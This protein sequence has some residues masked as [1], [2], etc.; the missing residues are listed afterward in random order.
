[1]I[2]KIGT[3]VGNETKKE[4]GLG[5]GALLHVG[6][7]AYLKRLLGSK[8]GSDAFT[9]AFFDAVAGKPQTKRQAFAKG[10]KSG[11]VPE[12]GALE[13]LASDMG[14]KVNKQL[15]S[16]G[17]QGLDKR[18]LLLAR[19]LSR[20]EFDTIPKKLIQSPESYAVL[21]VFNKAFGTKIRPKDLMN[22][23]VAKKLTNTW[24]GSES[25][26]Q[27]N[28][29]GNILSDTKKIPKKIVKNRS[30]IG[31][32]KARY[33]GEALTNAGLAAVDPITGGINMAKATL[34]NP[35]TRKA[36]E[37]VKPAKKV[38]ETADQKLL[39][40]PIRKGYERGQAGKT[41][42]KAKDFA[43]TYGLNAVTSD[44]SKLTEN[45]GRLKRL[46]DNVR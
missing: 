22:N 13:G 26:L 9:K 37:K 40:A 16:Q 15:A 32:A 2:L 46:T 35:F 31:L 43:Q 5:L 4:A 28:F 19:K 44:A 38:L 45:I 3:V 18:Q 27:K 6:Q 14:K 20:G 36:I 33:A 25:Q 8:K 24:Q 17:I 41:L 7:N 1:M 42:S 39:H 23:D 30:D 10:L 12:V 29:I 21:G 11:L 34:T